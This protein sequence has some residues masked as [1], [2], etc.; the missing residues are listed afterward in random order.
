[1]SEEKDSLSQTTVIPVFPLPNVVLFPK[2]HLPLHIFEPRY[3]E[4]VTAAMARDKLIG[5]AL[6][7]GDWEK[8]YQGNSDIYAVGCVGEIVSAMA[9]PDGRFNIVLYGLSEYE[10]QEDIL[11]ASPYRQ[12]KVRW[13]Q[14][15]RV[16]EEPIPK[17][18]R[19]EIVNLARRTMGGEDSDI[20][21]ILTDPSLA[22]DTWLNLCC[23][24]LDATML[25]KQSLLEAE[26]LH[27][28]ARRLL[29][30]LHFRLV[31]GGGLLE[32]MREPR[33]NKLPH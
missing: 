2:I 1:M 26:S 18:A 13:R 6:L 16:R 31:E 24:S 14:L 19:E 27:E 33:G 12:A 7:R 29:D 8:N 3:R 17:A 4:M 11:N 23:F 25:E 20:L 22:D 9:L 5:M 10:I 32:G 15:S 30:V 21:K 28:R